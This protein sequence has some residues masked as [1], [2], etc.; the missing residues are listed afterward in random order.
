[1]P[2]FLVAKKLTTVYKEDIERVKI[3]L[4]F[5]ELLEITAC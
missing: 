2:P 4:K 1:M 3:I 5:I